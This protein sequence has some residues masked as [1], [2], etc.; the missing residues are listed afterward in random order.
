MDMKQPRGTVG[1]ITAALIISHSLCA[2]TGIGPGQRLREDTTVTLQELRH[3]VP[4][5]ARVEMEKAY[6]ARLKRQAE[7]EIDHLKKAVLIDPD[8]IAARNDLGVRLLAIEP[9]S[10]IAQWEAA[11]KVDP[12]KGMLFNNLAV[13]YTV[14]RNLKAAERAARTSIEL[15][16]TSDRARALLGLVLFEQ[17]K[18]SAETSA[19]LER[20]SEAY[21]FAHVFTAKVLLERGEFQKARTHIQAYL[22]SGDTEHRAAAFEMLDIIDHAGPRVVAES[23][24]DSPLAQTNQVRRAFEG[25]GQ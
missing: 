9:T 16:G 12:H 22:S 14:T 4:K 11:I 1:C 3:V 8:Y 20:A 15:D 21:S 25:D 23:G 7:Q 10:A 6:R 5:A 13:G 18:Y 2:Q 17:R 19:L 24:P